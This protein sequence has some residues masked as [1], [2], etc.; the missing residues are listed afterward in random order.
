MPDAWNPEQY[1]R[2]Q[3]ERS[4][5]FFDLLALVRP[6]P[7]MRVADLGCGTGELTAIL[8]QR[9]AARETVGID[10]SPAMLEQSTAYTGPG[11]R[12]EIG[13]IGTFRPD[14]PFDLIFS[15]A[16]LQWVPNHPALFG[17]LTAALAEGGQLA[18]QVP[19]NDDHLS[20]RLAAEVA[21]EE[22]F[23]SALG[24][25]VRTSAILASEA[26][27]ALLDRLGYGEQH[28]RLQVYAHHLPSRAAVVDW[29]QGTLLTA[30]RE[31]LTGDRYDH[32]VERYREALL[33]GLPDSRPFFYPFTRIL[34]WASG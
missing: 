8:H 16:A 2:F 3:Q 26:Y 30:Y 4:Q 21:R 7:G 28:V 25:Y 11:L 19:A 18:V 34:L 13:D 17:R 14:R 6:R 5:P 1:A 31:R 24:G 20:H 10:S 33:D 29:V 15:N 27:S 12:F 32:F 9:L 22:P 23:A